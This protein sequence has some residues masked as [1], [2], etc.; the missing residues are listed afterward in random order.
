VVDADRLGDLGDAERSAVGHGNHPIVDT[1][2]DNLYAAVY[3]TD[4]NNT[5][6]TWRVGGFYNHTRN[7]LPTEHFERTVVANTGAAAARRLKAAIH[8]EVPTCHKVFVTRY[9]RA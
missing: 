7:I 8:A 2:L 6:Q 9:E 5:D 4:M 3:I 1:C